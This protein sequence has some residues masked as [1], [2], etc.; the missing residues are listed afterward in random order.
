[1]QLHIVDTTIIITYVIAVIIIGV[2][3]SK[4]ASENI[5]SYFLGGNKVPWYI[6]GTS[7]ASSMF[8]ITGTMWLVYIIFVYGLKGTLLPWLWPTFNQIFLMVYLS[9]WIRRSGVVTGGEWMGTRFGRAGG[10][11]LARISVVIFAFISVIGFLSYGFKGIGKFSMVFFPWDLSPDTYAMIIMSITTVYVILGGM[12]SVVITDLIQFALLTIVSLFIGY[13]AISQISPEMIAA[14]TPQGWNEL[15]FGWELGLDWSEIMPSVNEKITQDGWELFSIVVM[16]MLF[17]GFL[18][19]FAGP[20]PNYDLQRILATRNPKESALMSAIVSVCLLPRWLMITGFTVIALVYLSPELAAQGQAI[21]FEMILPYVINN[22]IPVG[23]M[24]LLLAG[25]LAGFM[26][27]F[28]S[29][30]NA[31]AS[32]LVVDVYKRYIKTDASPKQYVRMSYVASIFV[33]IVGFIFGMITESINTA[34]QWIVSGLW[35]GYTAPNL[36]KWHWWRLNGYGFFGGMI[37]GMIVAL[38]LPLLMPEL[39]A[40]DGFPIILVISGLT[41]I[42]LSLA[43]P[44]E[45]DSVLKKFYT[46]VRPWGIWGPVHDKVIQENPSFQRNGAFKRDMLNIIVG[47]VWQLTLV[48]VPVYMVLQEGQSLTV[49]VL[50][51]AITSFIL[52]KNWYDKL[53]D[54]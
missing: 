18:I 54:E 5:G 12:Y 1:M 40:L 45:D 19:S 53:E 2:Y 37:S 25:L 24:G 38:G 15:S 41:S 31:G 50:V 8:D 34:M 21:D 6:L 44:V 10:G 36:L 47:I 27:T 39:S 42:L 4:K 3:L 11:E 49:A 23:I 46:S 35:G 29:T 43:T 26:S 32:Y 16:M 7:N 9:I 51:L 28:D 33:V 20:S 22:F 14:A 13:I 30:V 52:K 48:L 17:K